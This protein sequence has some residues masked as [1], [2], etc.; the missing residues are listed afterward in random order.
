M[1]N[2]VVLNFA[3]TYQNSFLHKLQVKGKKSEI[4]HEHTAAQPAERLRR[5]HLLMGELWV[6]Q[7]LSN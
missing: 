4:A 5:R 1:W 3:L 7:V 6:V 2:V